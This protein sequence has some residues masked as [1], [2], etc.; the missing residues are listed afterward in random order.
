MFTASLALLPLISVASAQLVHQVIV[1][2]SDLTKQLTFQPYALAAA[3]GD[4]VQFV[5]QQKNH[6]VTQTSFDNVCHPLL[7]EY[8]K[9]V[10]DSGFQPVAADQKDD[11]PT[12]NYTVK[13][14]TPVWL[15]CQ[16]KG[17]CGQGMSSNANARSA[18]AC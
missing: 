1:G 9:P 16:Q 12:Y 8:Y 18:S 4:V 5:F 11:Y 13:D 3:P 14:T 7:D 6:T 17:H 2:S 15:Y 10:F